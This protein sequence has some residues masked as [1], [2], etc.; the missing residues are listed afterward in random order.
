LVAQKPVSPIQRRLAIEATRTPEKIRRGEAASGLLDHVRDTLQ[1][2][3][4]AALSRTIGL[5]KPQISKM[6]RGVLPIGPGILIRLHEES[7]ISIRD[8][9]SYLL[10]A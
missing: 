10:D 2:K 7:G 4:D 6:R 5:S 9:K 1:L 8:L 3:N